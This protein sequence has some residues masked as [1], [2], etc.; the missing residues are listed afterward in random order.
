MNLNITKEV[1]ALRRTSSRD[2]RARYAAL[3]GA[4][5]CA[6]NNRV[7]LIKRIAWRLQA[8]AEGDLS[9]RARQRALELANDADIRLSTPRPKTLTETQTPRPR[10]T[11]PPLAANVERLPRPGTIL[12]RVYKGE[13]LHVKVLEHGL[14]FEGTVYPSLSAVAKA[15]TGSHCN[16]FLFFRLGAHGGAR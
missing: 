7:W 16:G 14:A 1:A 3:F 12:T 2:L 15:I 9:Q 11:T 6:T 8:L 10:R 5:A 4:Q 13:A